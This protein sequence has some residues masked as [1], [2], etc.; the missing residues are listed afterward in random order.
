M[1]STQQRQSPHITQ[2]E[3]ETVTENMLLNIYIQIDTYSEI[4]QQMNDINMLQ[5]VTKRNLQHVFI[6]VVSLD[7][8]F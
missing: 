5:K 3:I 6:N 7:F 1:E 2:I 4:N 8:F